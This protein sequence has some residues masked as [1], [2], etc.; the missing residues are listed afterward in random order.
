MHEEECHNRHVAP[1]RGVVEWGVPL[2]VAHVDT[3]AVGFEKE[4]RLGTAL[5]S[6]DGAEVQGRVAVC[7]G[8]VPISPLMMPR[9]V[10]QSARSYEALVKC[11]AEADELKLPQADTHTHT[12]THT[13]T[14]DVIIS[15]TCWRRTSVQST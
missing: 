15:L 13:H 3:S 7:I 2:V 5:V 10:G 6:V 4:K 9:S 11:C 8:R 1:P 12:H 14:L